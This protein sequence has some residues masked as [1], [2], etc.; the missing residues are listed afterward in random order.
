MSESEKKKDEEKKSDDDKFITKDQAIK[1]L[2]GALLFGDVFFDD[3]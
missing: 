1:L 2:I 3:N